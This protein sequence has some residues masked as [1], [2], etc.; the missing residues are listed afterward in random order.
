MSNVTLVCTTDDPADTL[1]WH[2]K[3]KADESFDVQVVP[4][5]R[6][7]KAMG[8]N[9]PGF[10]DYCAKLSEVSGVTVN[11]FASLVD[12]LRVRLDYFHANGCTISDHSLDYVMYEPAT[13]EEVE[14]IVAKRLAGELVSKVEVKKFETAIMIE[15]GKEYHKKNWVM[16]LHY[17]VKRDNNK[18]KFDHDSC[19]EFFNFYF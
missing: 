8:I 14:A 19:F 6:P 15:L 17:G 7:E 4:A 11:S 13:A 5:W 12:A 16:Q 9:K 18:S 10:V 3:I 2:Q 1:E